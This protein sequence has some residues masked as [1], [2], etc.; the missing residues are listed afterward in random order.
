MMM[1]IILLVVIIVL[2]IWLGVWYARSQK[3]R[4]PITERDFYAL[5]IKSI[6]WDSISF[7][8]F[9]GKK[10]L[11]VNV[12]SECWFTDQY[13]SLQNLYE[14]YQ[15]QLVILGVPS[16]QFLGQEPW[17]EAQIKQFCQK[18]YGVS[19]LLAEKAQVFG[20][21]Q[22]PV[23]Q[24]L[25]R[26]ELNNVANSRVTRNFQKYLV[27]ESWHLLAHFSPNTIPFDKRITQYLV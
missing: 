20:P 9:R 12:A 23:Y 18:N 25:T 3:L 24:W 14:L 19:F 10:V 6:D 17:N 11:I 21:D 4:D 2:L 15:D 22:H 27:D 5:Q 7:E 16:N 26:K 13:A 1:W 8:Q